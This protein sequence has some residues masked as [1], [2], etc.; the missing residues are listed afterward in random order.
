VV[1]DSMPKDAVRVV[2]VRDE[3]DPKFDDTAPF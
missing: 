3:L 1:D 2:N